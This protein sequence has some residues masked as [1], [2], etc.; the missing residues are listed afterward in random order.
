MVFTVTG[1]IFLIIFGIPIAY[2]DFFLSPEPELEG[3]PVRI[4]NSEIIPQVKFNN[5]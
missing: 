5:H 3:H 1:V 4:N 2:E